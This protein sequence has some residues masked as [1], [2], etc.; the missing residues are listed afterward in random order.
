M[1]E[2]VGLAYKGGPSTLPERRRF[3][4]G[5]K[6]LAPPRVKETGQDKGQQAHASA[7]R[8]CNVG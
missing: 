8:C 3:Q 2:K 1:R 6:N 5:P 7:K 4:L